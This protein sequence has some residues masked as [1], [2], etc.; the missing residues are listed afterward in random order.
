MNSL[1]HENEGEQPKPPLPLAV[2]LG[3]V[4]LVFCSAA[5]A[6]VGAVWWMADRA[7][8][9]LLD[10]E[11]N[12]C[13]EEGATPAW[14]GGQ[15]GIRF[16]EHAS[17]RRAG[18]KV[19]QR[20]DTGLLSFVLPSEEAQTYADRLVPDGIEM[21]GNTLVEEKDYRPAATFTHLGLPEPETFSHD[22]RKT[23]LCPEGL[24]T[25]EGAQL[26]R[27]IDLFMH[28]FEPGTTRLYIRST[29]EPSVTPPPAV[30]E[31]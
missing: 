19:G 9:D 26:Q 24:D 29:I 1:V 15:M 13:W 8:S 11:M 27:C 31:P 10:Q 2:A 28:E 12:C 6:V 22:L 30:A 5:A 4:A 25:P 21:L 18:Y 3:I 23:G 7:E 16:P 20:Y 14:M 17:D